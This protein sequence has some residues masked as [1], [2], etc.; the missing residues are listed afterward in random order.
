MNTS[1]LLSPK[2]GDSRRLMCAWFF[3]ILLSGCASLD[4]DTLGKIIRSGG[5]APLDEATVAAGLKEALRVGTERTVKTTSA[6]DGF[7][8]NALIRIVLPEEFEGA[9]KTLRSIGL[10]KQVDE[11]ETTMNRAAERAAGE[12]TGIFWNAITGM[13]LADA[14][15]IL[16]GGETAATDYFRARTESGLRARFSPIVKEKMSELGLYTT[17][18]EL[19]DTYNNLPLVTRP[20]LDL[21]SYITDR[22]LDGLFVVLS[23]EER[24]IREDPLARTTDLLRR[25][26][27]RG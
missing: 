10:G 13:T 5:D 17:Y 20:A 16:N 19:A 9:A 6:L 27:E 14:F 18:N 1:A 24:R 3:L 7:L 11:F 21:D 22:A 15:G 4:S 25:V 12:A 8:G 2:N 26:F 23:Q